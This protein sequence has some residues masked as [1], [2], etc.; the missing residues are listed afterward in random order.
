MAKIFY[1]TNNP[2]MSEHQDIVDDS[3]SKEIP[4]DI[5]S[6]EE[7]SS[8]VKDQGGILFYPTTSIRDYCVVDAEDAVRITEIIKANSITNFIIKVNKREE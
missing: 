6:V 3:N 1:S 5:I 8:Y 4:S 7:M 2:L